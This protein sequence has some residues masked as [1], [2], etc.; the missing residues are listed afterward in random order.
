MITWNRT[1]VYR[2]TALSYRGEGNVY[3]PETRN[4]EDT[5]LLLIL[6]QDP[7]TDTYA[8]HDGSREFVKI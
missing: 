5:N 7:I 4:L 3:L 2:I 6:A 8:K 1:Y